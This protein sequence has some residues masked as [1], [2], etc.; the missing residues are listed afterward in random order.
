MTENCCMVANQALLQQN[1]FEVSFTDTKK[2]NSY[3][4]TSMNS[5]GGLIYSQSNLRKGM[6]KLYRQTVRIPHAQ[7]HFPPSD[8]S[9]A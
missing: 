5:R 6:P 3:I 9:Q 4:G 1:E 7:H 2:V 8:S